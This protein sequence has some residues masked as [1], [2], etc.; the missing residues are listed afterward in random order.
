MPVPKRARKNGYLQRSE[1]KRY[2]AG[3]SPLRPLY[4]GEIIYG[5]T[6]KAYRTRELKK[7]N[8]KDEREYGQVRRPE[9]TWIRVQAPA[10]RIVD[11]EIVARVDHRLSDRRARYLASLEQ[12]VGDPKPHTGSTCS[13]AAC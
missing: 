11:P 3:Y 1:A 10:L 2:G 13:R 9:D 7:V 12:P 6:K 4:R 5:R 8:R